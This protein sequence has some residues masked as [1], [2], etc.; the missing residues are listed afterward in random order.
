MIFLIIDFHV[1]LGKVVRG[2]INVL[3]SIGI[4]S[5][6]QVEKEVDE[7]I[8]EMDK[9]G[10]DK[11][12]VFPNPRLPHEYKLANDEIAKAQQLYPDR[13]IGFCR[14][15][16]R[17]L[18]IAI[19]ELERSVLTLGLKGLKLHPVMEVFTVD[20]DHIIKVV[21]KAAD[22]GIPVI[23]HSGMSMMASA[24][25]FN[26]LA[27]KVPEATIIMAHFTTYPSNI[28]VA[29][30]HK[31]IYL[32]TSAAINPKVIEVAVKEI[33]AERILY[34]SDWPYLD[35]RFEKL[36]IEL[37]NIDDEEKKLILGRNALRILGLER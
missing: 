31:N 16:P 28:L 9:Y 37:A 20:H 4:E 18:K 30:K 10:I 13:I 25:R 8:A 11:A 21:R 33:G 19:E 22:L 5:E 36:K 32:E 3:N 12:V 26:K 35:M 17:D 6:E 27:E 7:L 29:K 34:G 15:D 1:H 24:N 23:I 2:W 14:V